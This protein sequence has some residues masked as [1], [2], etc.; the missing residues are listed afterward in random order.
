M[1]EL[2][3]ESRQSQVECNNVGK[4]AED[5]R[6]NDFGLVGDCEVGTA[7]V[8]NQVVSPVRLFI[9]VVLEQVGRR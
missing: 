3:V 8:W 9:D 1:H 5:A 7:S 4:L 6:P 2:A